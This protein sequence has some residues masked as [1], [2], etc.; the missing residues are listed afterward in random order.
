MSC[1]SVASRAPAGAKTRNRCAARLDSL[2]CPG[3]L[4]ADDWTE[5]GAIA[6]DAMAISEVWAE[7]NQ[8]SYKDH[9]EP[10]PHTQCATKQYGMVSLHL[11]NPSGGS[12]ISAVRAESGT[13]RTQVCAGRPAAKRWHPGPSAF[14]FGGGS[15]QQRRTGWGADWQ[16]RASHEIVAC[17]R[18]RTEAVSGGAEIRMYRAPDATSELQSLR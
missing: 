13:C 6:Y 4:V 17:L 12:A 11:A 9:Y 18:E 7:L 10:E 15:D 2:H 8:Y 14:R 1:H 3:R 16:A 5:K